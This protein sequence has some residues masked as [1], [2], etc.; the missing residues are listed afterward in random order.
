MS[1]EMTQKVI[2]LVDLKAQY[3]AI[4][5]EMDAA[6]HRIMDNTSFIMGPEVQKLEEAFAKFCGTRYAIGVASGTAALHLALAALEIGPGDEVVTVSHTFIATAEPIATLGARAV[7]VDVDPAYFTLDPAKLEAAITP[8]TRAIIVV[9]LYG[10]CADMDAINTI[11]SKHDIPVIEDA[12]QAHGATY[13]GGT[14]GQLG[15]LAC[16]SFYPGKNLGGYGDG[17]A[18]ATDD[19]ALTERI[20]KLR[21]HGRR[22]KYVH[23]EVGYGERLDALQAAILGVKLPY[24][25]G[26]NERRRHW[27]S[28]YTEL[29]SDVPE[30]TLPAVRPEGDHVFHLYVIQTSA[31]DELLDYLKQSHVMAG[32]HYPLPLHLQ[33]AFDHLGYHAGDFPVTERLADT[34]LSLPLFPELTET[35][36]ARV[37]ETVRAFFNHKSSNSELKTAVA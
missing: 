15:R 10:Q 2:P 11:A 33:P 8:R 37:A 9:H 28:R 14:T 12:A 19:L 16:F 25:A 3:L 22:D 31:R 20:R 7:F 32:I 34:I 21:N 1:N 13:K 18:V 30:I 27:A 4:K 29:L 6:V 24:L 26:W 23:D 5:D 17:G 36:V 35:D